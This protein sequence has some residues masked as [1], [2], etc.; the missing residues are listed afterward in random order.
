[1]ADD[2]K[3]ARFLAVA[4][5]LVGI[6]ASANGVKEKLMK[7]D[8]E[9]AANDARLAVMAADGARAV[10][11]PVGFID[12]L[13]LFHFPHM[14]DEAYKRTTEQKMIAL[15]KMMLEKRNRILAARKRMLQV[16][17]DRKKPEV[18]NEEGKAPVVP[19]RV[20]KGGVA[21]KTP[22]VGGIGE[23]PELPSMKERRLAREKKSKELLKK[24]KAEGSDKRLKHKGESK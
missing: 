3:I 15:E 24:H 19:W 22:K 8:M 16:S 1:M 12:R 14:K 13:Y 2:M 9:M 20:G 21:V 6:T 10:V 18:L 17:L 7:V 23:P 11:S 4:V 5:A